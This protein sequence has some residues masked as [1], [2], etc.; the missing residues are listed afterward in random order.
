MPQISRCE[1]LPPPCLPGGRWAAEAPGVPLLCQGLLSARVCGRF[2]IATPRL[3]AIPFLHTKGSGPPPGCLAGPGPWGR[4]LAGGRPGPG[5]AQMGPRGSLGIL[6][7]RTTG[8]L[9][10]EGPGSGCGWLWSRGDAHHL[11]LLT[12]RWAACRSAGGGL[13]P[14]SPM[15]KAE[16]D[17]R[18]CVHSG[19]PRGPEGPER[20]RLA[21]LQGQGHLPLRLPAQSWL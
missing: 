15:N 2:P 18:R 1:R 13:S 14:L 8:G 17:W 5:W 19:S 10:A 4:V 6:R 12:R 21:L 11:S 16:P 3:A 9:G 7:G 20:P